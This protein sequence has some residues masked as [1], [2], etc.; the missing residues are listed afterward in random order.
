MPDL[1]ALDGATRSIPPGPYTITVTAP[2][3]AAVSHCQV[4]LGEAIG[5]DYR[6]DRGLVFWRMAAGPAGDPDR[7]AAQINIYAHPAPDISGRPSYEPA[8][9]ADTAAY[10]GL[11]AAL[12]RAAVRSALMSDGAGVHLDLPT[13][14]ITVRRHDTWWA[15]CLRGN[16]GSVVAVANF[17]DVGAVLDLPDL[18]GVQQVNVADGPDAAIIISGIAVKALT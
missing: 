13:P 6:D 18:S 1:I 17:A 14:R 2:D 4:H 10:R 11:R 15:V 5:V 3:G 16:A 8:F 9:T 7:Q 12:D